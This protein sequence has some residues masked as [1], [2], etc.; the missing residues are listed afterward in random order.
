MKGDHSAQ[1]VNRISRE[2]GR[3]E[4]KKTVR[5]HYNMTPACAEAEAGLFP[6]SL[7]LDHFKYMQIIRSVLGQGI[8]KL[9]NKVQE[10]Y[11]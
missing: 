6:S 11:L 8:H 10:S 3:I 9:I 4:K 7:L 5:H 1:S 2:G